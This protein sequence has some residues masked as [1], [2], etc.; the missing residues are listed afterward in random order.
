MKI[1]LHRLMLLLIA[2][3][4][5]LAAIAD[6]FTLKGK[7]V[8][9]EEH[10]LEFVTVMCPSQGKVTMTNLKG[11]FNLDMHSADSVEIRFS[12]TVS[13]AAQSEQTWFPAVSVSAGTYENALMPDPLNA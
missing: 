3:T 13:S 5:S 9:E 12:M 8:D 7:V 11:E 2:W 1:Y 6:D 4:M 10:A